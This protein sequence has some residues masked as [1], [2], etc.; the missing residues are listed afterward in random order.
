MFGIGPTMSIGSELILSSAP[1]EQ[2]SS[3]SAVQ[4]VGTGLGSALGIALMGSLAIVIYRKSLASSMPQETHTEVMGSV[5]DSI[6]AA[7]ASVERLPDALGMELL[8]AIQ[9]SFTLAIQVTYAIAVVG[10]VV[11]ALMVTWKLR[12]IRN[13]STDESNSVD[14]DLDL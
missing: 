8:Q 2:A 1:K 6:G 7:I 9:S 5:M 3:A 4:D 13:G 10:L 14:A 11:V 12:H